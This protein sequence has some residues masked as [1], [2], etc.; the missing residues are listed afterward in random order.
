MTAVNQNFKCYAG[1][2]HVIHVALTQADGSPFDPTIGAT[3]RWRMTQFPWDDTKSVVQK[4]WGNGIAS[5]SDGGINIT[6][7]STDM[8][9]K[10]GLYYHELKVWD[11]DDVNTALVGYIVIKPSAQM[12]D[13]PSPSAAELTASTTGPTR[14]P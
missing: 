8:D 14:E 9:L 11:G 6:M 7:S 10:P 5:A 2:S 1:N 13:H 4:E 3:L 12:N